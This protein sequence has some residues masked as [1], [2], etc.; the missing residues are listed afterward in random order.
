MSSV[1]HSYNIKI[2]VKT[3]SISEL[4]ATSVITPYRYHHLPGGGREELRV[5]DCVFIA[6]VLNSDDAL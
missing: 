3:L 1:G 2:N 6:V 5:N 4:F